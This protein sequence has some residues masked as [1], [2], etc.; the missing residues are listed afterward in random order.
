MPTPSRA[1]SPGRSLR[2]VTALLVLA[3]TTGCATTVVNPQTI[4][5]AQTLVRIRSAL[6][7]DRELG[8]RP[9]EI[10]VTA[11]T[12]YLTGEVGSAEEA[13][14]LV[15]LVRQ[16]SGV[17][18]VKSD[19]KVVPG[20]GPVPAVSAARIPDRP[21]AS[22]RRFLAIG[23]SVTHTEPREA[24]LGSNLGIGPLLRIGAGSGLAPTFA[25]NWISTPLH[26]DATSDAR[27]GEVRVRPIMGGLG[28]TWSGARTA[29]TVSLV[30]GY[31]FNSLRIAAVVPGQPVPLRVENS[32]A[33][34]PGMSVW[35]DVNRR[36]ALNGFA[37]VL[38]ARPDATFLVGD[39]SDTRELRMDSAVIR[40]GVAYKLF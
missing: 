26:A 5:D 12:A 9:I 19:V 33:W 2:T 34:R 27:L 36:I 24:T 6:V 37:G 39:R 8:T 4:A 25:F 16:V 30:A 11:G 10:R 40:L 31:A 20:L 22:D 32:F 21:E 17:V 23:V 29:A 38:V 13:G 1:A 18:A 28:Y 7:N 15:E 3:A 14:R 35:Y